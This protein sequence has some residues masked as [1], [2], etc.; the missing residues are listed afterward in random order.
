MPRICQVLGSEL[1]VHVQYVIDKYPQFKNEIRPYFK[2]GDFVFGLLKVY[3]QEENI[4]NRSMQ[5]D[6]CKI[7]FSKAE[8]KNGL[9]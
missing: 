6:A 8:Q 2:F 7:L 5:T 4:S 1:V 3:H 9:A